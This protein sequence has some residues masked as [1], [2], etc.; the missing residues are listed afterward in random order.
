MLEMLQRGIDL[1]G[2]AGTQSK[3]MFRNMK[4]GALHKSGRRPAECYLRMLQMGWIQIVLKLPNGTTAWTRK[5]LE[6]LVREF[7]RLLRAGE[8]RRSLGWVL[9]HHPVSHRGNVPHFHLLISRLAP[10][11]FQAALLTKRWATRNPSRREAALRMVRRDWKKWRQG[12]RGC[13]EVRAF[14]LDCYARALRSAGVSFEKPGALIRRPRAYD[15]REKTSKDASQVIHYMTNKNRLLR[16]LDYFRYASFAEGLLF[17]FPEDEKRKLMPVSE[18]LAKYYE[19]EKKRLPV[20]PMG[21]LN[22]TGTMFRLIT[23]AGV[24][25]SVDKYVKMKVPEILETFDGSDGP[26]RRELEA[27][28][29]RLP[30]N[31]RRA[32]LGRSRRLM[33]MPRDT[34]KLCTAKL[35]RRRTAP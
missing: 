25:P 18:F 7:N 2:L 31:I 1:S 5:R 34:R 35:L 4:F 24:M 32:V 23:T 22:P 9:H 33:E 6:R 29:H 12:E 17:K 3:A 20:R 26:K 13:D 8:H 27:N 15:F 19:P 30:T 28:M 14:V 11:R 16:K 10:P 21:L